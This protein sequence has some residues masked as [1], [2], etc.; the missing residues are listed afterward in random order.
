MTLAPT[1]VR[2]VEGDARRF[3]EIDLIARLGHGGMAEVFLAA[4]KAKPSELLVLKRLKSDL[5]DPE[6][7]AMFEDEARVMPLL[8][9]P[10]IVR[11]VQAGEEAGQ[12]YLAMEFLDGLPL[13]Q[14][15]PAVSKL[16][17]RA[18][19][20]VVTE[21]LEG[22]HYAHELCDKE[23]NSLDIVHRDVS[24]HNVFITY[25][26]RVT[27]VDFGIAKSKTKAQHTSTGVVRGKLSYM[28][29]E[30]ALC[31]TV[32]RRADVFAAGVV[33]WELLAGRRYWEGLSEVQI[34][35]RMTFGDMPKVS[36][37]EAALSPELQAAL[38]RALASK[39]EE[40]FESAKAFR[41]ALLGCVNTPFKRLELGAAVSEAASGY[42][43]AL[44]TVIESH[45]TKA[46]G[47][48]GLP[49]PGATAE[50]PAQEEVEAPRSSGPATPSEREA[51]PSLAEP[52]NAA[53]ASAPGLTRTADG[54][55]AGAALEVS[56]KRPAPRS[57][58]RVLALALGGLAAL[59]GVIVVAPR[60]LG[61]AA[62][63]TKAPVAS[64]TSDDN[65]TRIRLKIDV[66]PSFA[67]V[68]IDGRRVDRL[69]LDAEFP[70]DRLGHTLQVEAI[71]HAPRSQ[72]LVFDRDLDLLVKLE[73][74]PLADPMPPPMV[75][76]Q[77]G[78][79]SPR[80]SSSG[81]RPAQTERAAPS[82]SSAPVGTGSGGFIKTDPWATANKPK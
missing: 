7:R 55:D 44:T 57:S 59:A 47:T 8:T 40:R 2:L 9:H 45:L 24:P 80:V 42:R 74:V 58:G 12:R 14:C 34:L 26:G 5:D 19:L 30:Q 81:A 6:H 39:P 4:H 36:D 65:A 35:K 23:G 3:G 60:L 73:P 27:L 22:L 68:S 62:P 33:L 54:V 28:A 64:A 82:K 77:G 37:I 10:N 56:T 51:L 25:E 78:S 50:P 15:G 67:R 41:A 48:G 75:A 43:A 79:S 76:P 66:Q 21:L 29:P 17:E 16:G 49:M 69:P 11:T 52:L 1:S 53:D 70:R 46:R 18:V 32:D 72:I 31:D 71:G 20:H 13:D 61:G 63:E 38:E